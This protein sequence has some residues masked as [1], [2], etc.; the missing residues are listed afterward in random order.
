MRSSRILPTLAV[1]GCCAFSAVGVVTLP[2]G[3]VVGVLAGGVMLGATMFT[4]AKAARLD[5][6]RWWGPSIA[7]IAICASFIGAGLTLAGLITLLGVAAVPVLMLILPVCMWYKLP[8]RWWR[9]SNID[10]ERTDDSG[11]ACDS[12]PREAEPAVVERL[13]TFQLCHEWRNSYRMLLAADDPRAWR[14][15]IV[16][17]GAYLDELERRDP[18]GFSR[19]LAA[20]ACAG[21]DPHRFLTR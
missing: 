1:A 19:W 18:E 14:R 20:G 13:S 4:V 6:S 5:R 9:R 17:R 2:V 15:V 3:A 8:R 10:D 21:S 11:T 7:G 16:A 12:S